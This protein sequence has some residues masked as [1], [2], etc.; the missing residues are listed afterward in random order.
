MGYSATQAG[1]AISPGGFQVMLMLPFVG[2]LLGKAK[3]EARWLI[4]VGLIITSFALW[5]MTIF[6][7]DMSQRTAIIAR[8]YQSA[9]LAFLF[10][11]I[12]TAAYAFVPRNKNNQASGLINLMRN[13]GGSVGISMVTSILTRRTQ[14]H[15]ARLTEGM[16]TLNPAFNHALQGAH[17]S[18]M[19]HGSSA[20]NAANQAYGVV[21]NTV[22]RQASVLAYIDCFYI[23]AIVFGAMI[24][25]VFLMKKVKAGG[26]SMGH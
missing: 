5:H 8:C 7:T 25:L 3:V 15:Q 1:L 9:G 16:S 20:A 22:L 10:V 18:L 26:V 4:M 6:N 21:M 11:P 2:L 14:Y 12:N 23:L 19:R 17:N 24:P 13:V